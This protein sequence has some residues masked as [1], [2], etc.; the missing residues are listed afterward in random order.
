MTKKLS[1]TGPYSQKQYRCKTCGTVKT[2]GTNH[3]GDVY[4]YCPVCREIT[5]WEC[6]EPMPRGY[7]KPA[8]WRIVKLGDVARFMSY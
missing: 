5:V 8:P 7:K 1:I 2:R 6:L 3:W 4:P